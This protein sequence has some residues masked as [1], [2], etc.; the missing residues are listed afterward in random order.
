MR[1]SVPNWITCSRTSHTAKIL[2]IQ[3]RDKAGK[4]NGYF[5]GTDTFW[6]QPVGGSNQ[7]SYRAIYVLS[8]NSSGK[9]ESTSTSTYGVFPPSPPTFSDG[10][11][12]ISA[13][14]ARYS[15]SYTRTINGTYVVKVYD[16]AWPNDISPFT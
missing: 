7:N 10:S 9:V 15:S 2:Y 13:M 16:L 6:Y 4:R 8:T 3:V 5:Y 12:S 11:V 14:K 1:E